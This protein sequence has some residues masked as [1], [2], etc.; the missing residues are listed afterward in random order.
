M[1]VADWR[2]FVRAKAKL[3]PVIEYLTSLFDVNDDVIVLFTLYKHRRKQI[4]AVIL[5]PSIEVTSSTRYLYE[6]FLSYDCSDRANV[7]FFVRSFVNSVRHVLKNLRTQNL[8]TETGVRTFVNSTPGSGDQYASLFAKCCADR[9]NGCRDI[10][11]FILLGC[12]PPPSSISLDLKFV[13][14]QTVTRAELRH[15]AKVR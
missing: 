13:T 7:R 14:D 8:R 12:R 9:S 5:K 4:A 1:F 11:I 2:Q 10:V 6:N 3:P 15:H